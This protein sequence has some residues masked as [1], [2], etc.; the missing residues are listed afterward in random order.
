M[1]KNYLLTLL[2]VCLAS[3]ALVFSQDEATPGAAPTT[4]NPNSSEG[5]RV[6]DNDPEVLERNK[7]AALTAEEVLQTILLDDFEIAQGWKPSIPLDFGISRSIYREGSPQ[8][9]SSEN[10]KMALGVKTFFFKRNFGWMSVDRNYPMDIK[11]I[12]RSFSVW[13]IGRNRSHQLFIKVRD[14][15][16]DHMRIPA[17]EMRWYG[18]KKL[19]V[20]VGDSVRQYS[21][22]HNKKGLDFFGFHI[23]FE[24]EDI[25]VTDPYFLYFDYLTATV[26]LGQN[27]QAD[28]MKDDW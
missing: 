22:K 5:L 24:A 8:E 14:I 12:V 11:S 16:N 28:D 4:T 7:G 3:P 13:V 17:G 2:F 9:L 21:S 26:N 18:W 6:V 10:N 23:A 19:I 1:K 27:P 15:N 20:P 25:V